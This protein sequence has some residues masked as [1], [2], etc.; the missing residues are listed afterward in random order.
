MIFSQAIDKKVSFVYNL[1]WNSG[2]S[3]L[4]ILKKDAKNG[5]K[6]CIDDGHGERSSR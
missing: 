5:K 1:I 2:E 4:R 6:L 3:L